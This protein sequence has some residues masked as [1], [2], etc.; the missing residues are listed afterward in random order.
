MF[1]PEGTGSPSHLDFSMG[2]PE[3]LPEVDG[4]EGNC[5]IPKSH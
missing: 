3:P 5:A 2:I 4:G 1:L